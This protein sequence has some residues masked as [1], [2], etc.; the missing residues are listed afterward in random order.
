M[1]RENWVKKALHAGEKTSGAWLSLTNHISAEIMA[2]AGFDWLLVDCEHGPTSIETLLIQ[3]QAMSATQTIPFVRAPWNDIVAIKRILDVGAYGVMIPWVNNREQAE[4]A[5]KACKYPPQ[6]LRGMAGPRATG[7]GRN[8]A[9]YIKR[10]NDEVLVIVQIETPEAVKNI[11]EILSVDGIDV[12]FI[13]PTDLSALMNHPGDA[14]HPEV[15]AAIEQVEQAAKAANV[16]LGTISRSW[17]QAKTL[18]DRG[19]Q[20]ITLCSDAS[21]IV[22]GSSEFAGKFAKE[23]RGPLN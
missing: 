1:I 12:A 5:V 20:F 10:A 16:P 17:E 23:V 8:I 4:A 6:G 3:L 18:Y 19:Y 7:Y 13:G 15:Q 14:A 22:Q 9:D 2:H 21:L 11:R